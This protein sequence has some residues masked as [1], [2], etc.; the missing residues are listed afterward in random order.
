[1]QSNGDLGCITEIN[2]EYFDYY[3]PVKDLT[4]WTSLN[5]VNC[6]PEQY[7]RIG[8]NIIYDSTRTN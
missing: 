6:H 2:G 4:M 7:K 1:M 8:D 5:N 3:I